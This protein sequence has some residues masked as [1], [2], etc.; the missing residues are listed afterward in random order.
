M[1]CLGC[2]KEITGRSHHK[3][4]ERKYCCR[5]C[6]LNAIQV[7]GKRIRICKECGEPF[8]ETRYKSVYCSRTCAGK[9]QRAEQLRARIDEIMDD[10][11]ELATIDPKL[12]FEYRETRERL[13]ELC[14]MILRNRICPECGRGF[15]SRGGRAYC[16]EE[17]AKKHDNRR[18]NKR[19]YRNGCPDLSV[20]LTKLYMRDGGICQICGKAIDFDRDSNADDYPSIDHII[21]LSKGGLHK[22]DNVQLACRRCNYIKGN[23]ITTE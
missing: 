18:R 6:Q 8:F 15:I 2:G 14:E 1:N 5:Q 13:D 10:V 7:N 3:G 21:P 20:T 4:R 19:I 23:K 9:A 12:V 11:D 16:S 22:W 17:C